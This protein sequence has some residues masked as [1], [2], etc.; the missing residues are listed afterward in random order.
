M[1]S[2]DRRVTYTTHRYLASYVTE[3]IHERIVGKTVGMTVLPTAV[4]MIALCLDLPL[5]AS[6]LPRRH[7]RLLGSQWDD[8]QNSYSML[9]T[10]SSE[11][12]RMEGRNVV[13]RISVIYFDNQLSLLQTNIN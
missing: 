12:S 1:P 13:S 3:L 2:L 8:R 9:Y 11:Y 4:Q 5:P 6:R 7:R 10:D